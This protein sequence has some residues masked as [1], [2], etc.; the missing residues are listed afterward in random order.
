M[1]GC[2]ALVSCPAPCLSTLHSNTTYFTFRAL[3]T[4]QKPADNDPLEDT[5]IENKKKA[6]GKEAQVENDS[7]LKAPQKPHLPLR[8]WHLGEDY[9]LQL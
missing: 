6:K 8:I 4:E 3:L 1:R 2:L 9:Q 5:A 7:T